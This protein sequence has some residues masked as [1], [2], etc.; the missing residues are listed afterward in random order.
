M[1]FCFEIASPRGTSYASVEEAN[2]YLN[3]R[4]GFDVSKWTELPDEQKQFRLILAAL[5]IDSVRYAGVRATKEQRLEF[6]RLLSG[7]GL[8]VEDESGL[9]VQFTDWTALQDY[10]GLKGL[11]EFPAVPDDVKHAQA[12]VAFQIVHSHMLTLGPGESGERDI[13]SLGIDVISLSFGTAQKLAHDLFAKQEFGAASVIKLY[14]QRYLPKGIR[15]A[16]V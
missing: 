8:Y 11:S 1:E 13:T 9:P 10:A 7:N 6:P 4:S 12:E 14:L 16:L 2:E 5:I 3:A 15:G